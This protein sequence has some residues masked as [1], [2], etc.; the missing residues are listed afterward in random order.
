MILMEQSNFTISSPDFSEDGLNNEFAASIYNNFDIAIRA[1]NKFLK[2]NQDFFSYP[3]GKGIRGHLLTYGI[4]RQIYNDAYKPDAIYSVEQRSL[5]NFKYNGLILYRLNFI[6]TIGRTQK[7][8]IL[9]PAA[10]YKKELAKANEGLDGQ[11]QLFSDDNNTLTFGQPYKYAQII[12]GISK[13]YDV[14]N[15]LSIIVP[16]TDYTGIVAPGIDLLQNSQKYYSYMPEVQKEE[17]IIHLKQ[18][19][20]AKLNAH[21]GNS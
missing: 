20:D 15:H 1:F 16:N 12:Y 13:D 14:L 18:S 9:L 8:N 19:L 11:L 10:G 2:S 3:K 21:A 17:Q 6:L 7:P 4:E 5:N